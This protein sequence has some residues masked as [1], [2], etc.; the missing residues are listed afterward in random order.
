MMLKQSRTEGVSAPLQLAR[1]TV[2]K[3]SNSFLRRVN[4][5]TLKKAV[6]LVDLSWRGG[7]EQNPKGST[8]WDNGSKVQV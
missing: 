1:L 7:K 6:T 5:L 4:R 8:G 3:T 2:D